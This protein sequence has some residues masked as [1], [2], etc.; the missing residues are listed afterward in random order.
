MGRKGIKE[1]GD[2]GCGMKGGD[3]SRI[4]AMEEM[5]VGRD[6]ENVRIWRREGEGWKGRV[7]KF[8]KV[9]EGKKR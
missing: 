2:V 9:E 3:V 4:R 8:R 6:V 5:G 1:E 7:E